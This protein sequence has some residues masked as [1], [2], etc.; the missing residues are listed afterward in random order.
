M[1][2]SSFREPF[3][4]DHPYHK[5]RGYCITDYAR[6]SCIFFQADG[7]WK[8]AGF[9]TNKKMT[10]QTQKK[11]YTEMQKILLFYLPW[12]INITC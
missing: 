8:V 3:I 7:L 2:F 11:I 6:K 1:V 5:Y 12:L 10:L 4:F 9:Y